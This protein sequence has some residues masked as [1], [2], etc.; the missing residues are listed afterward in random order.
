MILILYLIILATI[1]IIGKFSDEYINLKHASYT[2]PIARGLVPLSVVLVKKNH[3][4]PM[5]RL[6][7]LYGTRGNAGL[8]I[9]HFAAKAAS[10]ILFFIF[11]VVYFSFSTPGMIEVFLALALPAAG[12]MLPDLDLTAKV[13]VKKEE[14]LRGYMR[15]CTDL[16]VMSGAGLDITSAWEEAVKK[17]SH[18]DFVSEARRAVLRAST[19][20]MFSDALKEMAANLSIPEVH[21]FVTLVNQEIKSGSGGMQ[22]KLRECAV[23][24]WNIREAEAK[25]KGEEAASKMVFPLAAGL[26]G[27]LMILAAP[28]VMIMKGV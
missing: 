1:W 23:R 11:P 2:I 21:T 27:I 19:G 20:M 13:K 5:G 7:F 25:R 6:L 26:M 4:D 14:V 9:H 17:D 16:A 15:F 12:Y 18:N 8:Y 10:C 24:S 22:A 28:A 3:P